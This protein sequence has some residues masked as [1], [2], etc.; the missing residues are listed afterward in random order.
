[1]TIECTLCSPT[2][3]LQSAAQLRRHLLLHDQHACPLCDIVFFSDHE[4]AQHIALECPNSNTDL[5]SGCPTQLPDGT[6]CGRFNRTAQTCTKCTCRGH[7]TDANV[8]FNGH[9][10]TGCTLYTAP[11]VCGYQ[12][13]SS[14]DS[15]NHL[16]SCPTVTTTTC[17]SPIDSVAAAADAT[18]A[19]ARGPGQEVCF[20]CDII[21]R[22][23]DPDV[24]LR[25]FNHAGQPPPDS[26]SSLLSPPADLEPALIEY[27]TPSPPPPVPTQTGPTSSYP[28]FGRNCL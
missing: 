8:D 14:D 10:P 5:S 11:C 15:A 7:L 24:E 2:L 9:A 27:Y 19:L 4:L 3:V 23:I 22:L 18:T 28:L 12:Y 21:I 20:C 26:V 6:T 13:K 16:A 1:M 17:P 25:R